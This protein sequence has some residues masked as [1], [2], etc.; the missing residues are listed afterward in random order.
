MPT[1]DPSLGRDADGRWLVECACG[2]VLAPAASELDARALFD[3]HAAAPDDPRNAVLRGDAA[4]LLD[5]LAGD[6][7]D[8][9]FTSPPYFNARDYAEYE[10]YPAYLAAMADV[11]AEVLRVTKAGRYLV[12]NSSPVLQRRPVD[13]SSTESTRLPLPFDLHQ[14]LAAMGWLFVDDLIWRKP[15]GAAAGRSRGWTRHGRTPLTWKPELVTEYLMV[16]RKRGRLTR[17]VLA[18][19]D[20]ETRAASAMPAEFERSNVWEIAPRSDPAHP[21]VFPVELAR[22]IVAAYSFAGDLV[23]DPF[24]G[25]GTTGAAAAELGRDYILVERDAAYADTAEQ[26]LAQGR[27]AAKPTPLQQAQSRPSE[28]PHAPSPQPLDYQCLAALL[29]AYSAHELAAEV[30]ATRHACGRCAVCSAAAAVAASER[31]P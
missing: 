30:R 22:R 1:H 26:R 25:T 29:D 13:G 20:A 14:R 21:A 24:A 4:L 12:V 2:R 15:T 19:Y 7:V 17:D 10:S 31:T 6:T 9:T 18:D 11:F 16:Y 23:L 3:V 8:L 5:E 28:R 27:L